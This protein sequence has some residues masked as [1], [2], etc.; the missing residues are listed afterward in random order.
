MKALIQRT[1][2]PITVT[3][4][5]QDGCWPVCCDPN[6][7]ENALL[8]LAINS[9]DALTP[10][11]GRSHRDRSCDAGR[12]GHTALERRGPGRFRADHGADTGCGMPPEVMAHAFEPFF[13]TKPEGQ[14]PG[15]G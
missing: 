7:L 15:S 14:G 6:Q 8:N 12:G 4:R 1:S 2:A 10:D 5:L 11:G 13:T 9:R 3:S